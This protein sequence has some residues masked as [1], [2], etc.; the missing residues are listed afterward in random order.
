MKKK[1]DYIAFFDLDGTLLRVASGKIVIRRAYQS[2]LLGIRDIVHAV[3]LLLLHKFELKHTTQIIAQLPGLLSGKSELLI[4]D[5]TKKIVNNEIVD[6]IRPEMREEILRH[7]ANNARLV[8]LSAA[9]TY[10]CKP[11]AEHLKIDDVI[12]SELEVVNGIFTGKPVGELCIREEKARKLKDFCAK[13]DYPLKNTYFYGDSM[14]DLPGLEIVGH[15]VCINPD[16][17]LRK[18]AN[19]KGWEIRQF[20]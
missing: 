14:D 17:N 3:Y 13:Y 15:P 2:D 8:I 5:F 10:I 7:K 11:I 16:R 18:I 4:S 9:M 12:C 6:F 20:D 1:F 19:Q